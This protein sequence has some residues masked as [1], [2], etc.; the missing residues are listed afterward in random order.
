MHGGLK[1]RTRVNIHSSNPRYRQR[2]NPRASRRGRDPG[3][4]RLRRARPIEAQ[5]QAVRYAREHGGRT[6]ESPRH[7]GGESWNRPSRAGAFADANSTSFT[8]PA[9]NPVI[10]LI[11]R[12]AG[13][14]A[15]RANPRTRP[16]PRAAP[17][18]WEPRRCCSGR[19]AGARD[20]RAPKR[21]HGAPSA[22][23]DEINKTTTLDRYRQSACASRFSRDGLGEGSSCQTNPWFMRRSSTRSS[24]STPR[25]AATRCSR[26]FA[27]RRA[28][29]AHRSCA[30]GGRREPVQLDG[31]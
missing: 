1:S 7:A 31:T 20:L 15:R 19:H 27:G 12:V 5:I 23:L 13:P 25:E 29:S 8:V 4:R 2:G 14:D 11:F 18:A 10:A 21:Q 22:P 6:W 3:A 24:T 28:R 16:A 17:C 26:G 9:R 30:G